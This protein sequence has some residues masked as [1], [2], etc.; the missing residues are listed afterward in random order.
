M[1]LRIIVLFGR[2]LDLLDSNSKTPAFF[3]AGPFNRGEELHKQLVG[4]GR[5]AWSSG[6]GRV[7]I[8]G[9][10]D[11]KASMFIARKPELHSNNDPTTLLD[12]KSCSVRSA[13]TD[14]GHC[15]NYQ[16]LVV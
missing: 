10:V 13:N 6:V 8:V 15:T 14:L 2:Q 4:T 12:A 16:V 9:A 5:Q 1:D 7:V 3:G 11:F